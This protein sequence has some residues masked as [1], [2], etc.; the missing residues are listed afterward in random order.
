MKTSEILEKIPALSPIDFFDLSCDLHYQESFERPFKKKQR[1]PDPSALLSEDS[2][3]TIFFGWNEKGVGLEVEID[4]PF[5][6][7]YF[8]K[9]REGDSLELFIDTR[10][11][12]SS[13]YTT[14]FCHHFLFLPKPAGEIRAQ[15]I[16]HFRLEDAHP[17]CEA[18]LLRM[19]TEF[20]AKKYKMKIFIPSDC[21]YGYDPL[22]FNRLGFTYRLNRSGKRVQHFS[23]SSH[24]YNI[25]KHPGLWASFK[26]L[27]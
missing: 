18:D 23:V 9:F 25:E 16:T 21:L 14:K 26:L 27:K 17:L 19:E 13:G 20:H 7:C 12:K 22:S 8:P 6:N 3:A 24:Y 4:A 2:F 10:D 11:L 1:L 15:E 5:E